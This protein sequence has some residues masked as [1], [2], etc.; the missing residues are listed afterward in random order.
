MVD[1]PAMFDE[2]DYQLAFMVFSPRLKFPG[3]KAGGFGLFHISPHPYLFHAV[4]TS[5]SIPSGTLTQLWKITIEI[6]KFPM[7][8]GDFP[9]RFFGTVYQAGYVSYPYQRYRRWD[10]CWDSSISLN[11][12]DMTERNDLVGGDWN[13]GIL[14]DFPETVGK[15]RIPTDFHSMKF[16]EG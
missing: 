14:N 12:V 15:F 13:H 1:F 10:I 4:F 16:S 11:T 6:V 7:K 3:Q 5:I 2:F 8:H 9:V